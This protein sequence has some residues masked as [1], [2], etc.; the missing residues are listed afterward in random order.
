MRL[1]KKINILSAFIIMLILSA[2]KKDFLDRAPLTNISDA[3]Y[4]KTTNDLQLYCNNFY[5]TFPAYT[6]FGSIGNFTD[7][8]DQG[9]DNMIAEQVN[10]TINGNR[11][12]PAS[13]GGWDWNQLKNVNYFLANYQKVNAP[14]DLVKPYVG[15]ALF[16]RAQFYFDKLKT[17]GAVPWINKPILSLDDPTL[18]AARLPRN[19]VADSIISDL[20]KA[21][22]YLPS[23]GSAK[24]SRI[25]KEVAMLYLSRIALFEGT[26]EKYHAGTPFGIVG[27]NGAKFLQK[28]ADVAGT[29]VSANVYSLDNTLASQTNYWNLFN[30]TDYAGSREVML[31]RRYEVGV[32]SHNWHRYS[33]GGAGRGITKNL[34]DDYLCTDGLPKTLSPLYQGDNTLVNVAKNRDPRLQQTIYVNDGQHFISTNLPNGQANVVF[35]APALLGGGTQSNTTGYQLYKGH[36][37]NY[38]QQVV[39]EVGTTGL[40]LFRY[41]EA[42]LNLAEAKAELGSLS[43]TD[44]DLT[45]NKLR[46]RAGMPPL[47]IAAIVTDPNWIFPMLSPVINEVRRERRVELACEGYRRDDIY[48]WAAADELLVGWKPKGAKKAQFAGAIDAGT[49]AKYPED[50]NGYIEWFKSNTA[51]TAG[52]RFNIDRDYLSPLPA[53]QLTLNPALKPQNPGW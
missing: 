31:W 1:F 32:I 52:Y 30:Q 33:N 44:V 5:A 23:K 36:N 3:E 34:V 18:F 43:Q 7:D 25:N 4:W 46:T 48:R 53:N 42:L 28:A 15:E 35:N 49:L 19:I 41:A 14:F 22:S 6:G 47:V 16:F 24:A 39:A 37:A 9:S 8:A 51:L 45:I 13:G 10:N 11:T 27:S 26:W 20:D 21:I 40:I 17:F 50:A 29:L 38:A 2:C 12:V